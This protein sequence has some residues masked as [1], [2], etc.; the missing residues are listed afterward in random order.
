MF[1]KKK[2]LHIF[3]FCLVFFNL[4]FAIQNKLLAQNSSAYNDVRVS[5]GRDKYCADYDLAT[6][7]GKGRNSGCFSSEYDYAKEECK[8]PDFKFDPF[9]NNPDLDCSP[10][11]HKTCQQKL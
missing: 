3:I 1:N 5:Q 4:F 10:G 9:G 7:N 6:S 2:L 11:E 8:K